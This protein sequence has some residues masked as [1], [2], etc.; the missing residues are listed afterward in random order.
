MKLHIC[1]I[2]M[3]IT[4][5]A[6]IF[7]SRP[8]LFTDFFALYSQPK[9]SAAARDAVV[10]LDPDSDLLYVP[11]FEGKDFF[12]SINDM[13]IIRRADVRGYIYRYLTYD[14]V[15]I[16]QS[17]RRAEKYRSIIEP[18]FEKYPEIPKELI[19]LPLL[20]SG[21]DPRAVSRSQATGLW[22]FVSNT[23]EPLGLKNDSY[24]DER[25]NIV[26]STDA[27][28]R[29]LRSLHARFGSWE[30]ALAA[31][32]GGAGYISRT[33]KDYTRDEFWSMVDG[34]KFRSE[35]NE[36]LP[37]YAALLLIYKNRRH[38]GLRHDIDYV[39]VDSVEFQSPVNI[40][41]LS[42]VSG[43][44]ESAIRE[45][46][47]EIKGDMT[48]PYYSSYHLRVTQDMKDAVQKY[49]RDPAWQM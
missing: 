3:S 48:P 34:K 5:A 26:K 30:L 14:R 28:L 37:R 23:S 21:F 19:L 10:R 27:A 17:M 18:V 43:V 22:Q 47:P 13:S 1:I 46:N 9:F 25:R 24:V 2:C 33:M 31:Y 45:F 20:E 29:H 16:V 11:P 6:V 36:Y 40:E 39:S 35:T 15:Y 12:A 44:P 41:H 49:A 4:T 38:F 32:N 8:C 7:F 42:S